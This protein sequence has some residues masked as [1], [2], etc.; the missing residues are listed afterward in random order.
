MSIEVRLPLRIIQKT[1][2]GMQTEVVTLKTECITIRPTSAA[3]LPA[4]LERVFA[5]SP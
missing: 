5:G 2:E 4:T 3:L 1:F